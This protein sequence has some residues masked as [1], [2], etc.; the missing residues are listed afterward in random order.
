MKAK[1]L[2]I[3]PCVAICFALLTACGGNAGSTSTGSAGGVVSSSRHMVIVVEENKDF[4]EVTGSTN[5]TPNMPFFTSLLPKGALAADYFGVADFSLPNYFMLTTGQTLTPNDSTPIPFPVVVDN[6]VRELGKANLTWKVYAEGLPFVGY[7]GPDIPNN[8]YIQ[9]H[10]PFVFFSDVVNNMVVNN[11]PER[12]N[13][14]P[15]TQFAIDLSNNALPNYAF[16][17][18]NAI[19][20]GHACRVAGCT[21]EDELT[22]TDQFLKLNIPPLLSNSVFLNENGLLAIVWDSSDANF[23]NGGGHVAMLLLGAGVNKGVVS[24]ILY[25]HPSLLRLSMKHLRLQS[26]LGAA[27]SAPDMSDM[28]TP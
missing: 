11:V 15:F 7:I 28:V 17:V 3:F 12:Q 26:L 19:D 27:S 13:V 1:L 10:N 24:Q 23:V 4:S 9:H 22:A 5:S 25:Q 6:I 8:F 20:D 14:V 18:P 16:I 2:P 21:V